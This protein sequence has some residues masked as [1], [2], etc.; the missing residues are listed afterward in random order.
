M[1]AM[2][3]GIDRLTI[4]SQLRSALI[5]DWRV[6]S[7]SSDAASDA[8][9]SS[10]L[11]YGALSKRILKLVSTSLISSFSAHDFGVLVF[12]GNRNYAYERE[13]RFS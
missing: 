9:N 1:R 7:V 12:F 13:V 6:H 3:V 2:T 5:L 11:D 8:L 10:T 4:C